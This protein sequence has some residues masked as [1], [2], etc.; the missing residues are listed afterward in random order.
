MSTTTTSGSLLDLPTLVNAVPSYVVEADPPMANNPFLGNSNLPEGT[1]FIVVGASLVGALFFFLTWRIL[2]TWILRI[3]KNDKRSRVEKNAFLTKPAKGGIYS[4][5]HGSAMSVDALSRAGE[6]ATMSPN[7]F[8]TA[9]TGDGM[10]NSQYLP[11]GFYSTGSPGK[12]LATRRNG[13][14]PSTS[15]SHA[16]PAGLSG[17]SGGLQPTPRVTPGGRQSRAPSAYLEDLLGNQR[18]H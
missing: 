18:D 16:R 11:A 7:R 1:V 6:F 14:P 5:S 17:T 4:D 12:P 9:S 10:R 2:A 13:S 8:S 3:S 15:G